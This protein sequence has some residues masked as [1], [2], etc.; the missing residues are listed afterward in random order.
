MRR[1]WQMYQQTMTLTSRE[2]LPWPR[3]VGWIRR[4]T[5]MKERETKSLTVKEGAV[6]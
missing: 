2:R 5:M 1:Q 4:G 6:L 3:I